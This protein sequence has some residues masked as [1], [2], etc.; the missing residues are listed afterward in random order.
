MQEQIKTDKDMK[1]NKTGYLAP[2]CEEIQL[3]LEEGLL[4]NSMLS[5]GGVATNQSYNEDEI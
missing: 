4:G 1:S 5:P 3:R 2:E